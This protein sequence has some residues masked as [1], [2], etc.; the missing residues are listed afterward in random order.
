MPSKQRNKPTVRSRKTVSSSPSARKNRI[1]Q[2]GAS[3]E[4]GTSSPAPHVR[5]GNRPARE[6]SRVA[7]EPERVTRAT[8]RDRVVKEARHRRRK[9]T[10]I[11][12]LS[13]LLVICAAL[14]VFAWDRYF[15][16]DD[17]AD[18]Q[19]QWRVVEQN[20]S[21]TIDG[22]NINMPDGLSYPYTL[23]TTKKTI[24]YQFAGYTGGGSYTF[25][26]D[27][28]SFTITEGEGESASSLT[29]VKMNDDI[30]AQPQ[31]LTT[32]TGSDVPATGQAGQSG[33]TGQSG[34]S[35]Q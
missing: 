17:A 23:D 35:G 31:I 19:G 10:A 6:P 22:E 30:G 25:A 20:M 3:A 18:I 4:G 12:V 16:Y 28:S 1:D 21:V 15:R 33:Q 14:G 9:R 34:Q 32:V 29:F 8:E 2:G 24:A 13:V 27:R 7:R 5:R 11:I 26:R